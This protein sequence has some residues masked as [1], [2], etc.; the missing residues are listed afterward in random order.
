MNK[1]PLLGNLIPILTS[2]FLEFEAKEK[3][4]GLNTVKGDSEVLYLILFESD[5][6]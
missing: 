3:P 5:T 1:I 2:D 4:Y 6:S